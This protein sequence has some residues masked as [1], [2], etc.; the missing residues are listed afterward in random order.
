M[1]Q[2]AIASFLDQAADGLPRAAQFIPGA[3]G[4]AAGEAGKAA[5]KLIAEMLRRG[6]T[7]E[8]VL[9]DIKRDPPPPK[10]DTSW[11][12]LEIEENRG[13]ERPEKA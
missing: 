2:E 10:V 4:A 9:E 7:L 6:K 1:S 12:D 8:Q 13:T 11:L 5:L 3:A